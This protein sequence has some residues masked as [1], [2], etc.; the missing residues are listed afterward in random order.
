MAL[1]SLF[2]NWIKSESSNHSQNF[3]LKSLL[4]DWINK[5]ENYAK[6]PKNINALNFGLFQSDKGF[7]IYLTGSEIYN[8]FDDDWA[9]QIDYEPIKLYKYLLLNGEEISDLK[10]W[11]EILEL[12]YKNIKEI[13]DEHPDSVLFKNKVITTGFDDGNLRVIK[14]S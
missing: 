13:I 5:I 8:A 1:K 10:N 6:P 12:V 11:D 2:K 7:M 3:G 14:P 9:S 4:S